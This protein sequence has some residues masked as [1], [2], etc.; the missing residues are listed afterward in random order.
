MSWQLDLLEPDGVTPKATRTNQNPTGVLGGFGWKSSRYGNCITCDF[1]GHMPSLGLR[2]RDLVRLTINGTS[3][4]YGPAVELPQPRDPK[5]GVVNLVGA[6]DL[7]ERRVIGPQVY[8]NMDVALI[9]RDLISRHRHPAL[10]YDPAAI[11]LTGK[12]LS[13]FTMPWRTLRQALESLGKT[14]GGDQGVPFGV[15]PSGVVFFGAPANPP[16]VLPYSAVSKSLKYLRVSGDDVVTQSYLIALSQA[17]GTA[18]SSTR[19]YPVGY[20]VESSGVALTVSEINTSYGVPYKPATYTVLAE[21]ADWASVGA[22]ATHLIPDG[23]DVITTPGVNLPVPQYVGGLLNSAN[24]LDGNVTTYAENDPAEAN[25][26]IQFRQEMGVN[27]DPIIGFRL[28]YSLTLGN[29]LYQNEVT[30]QYSYPNPA[31]QTPSPRGGGAMMLLYGTATFDFRLASTQGELRELIA[32]RPMPDEFLTDTLNGPFTA[33]TPT[34]LI[35]S[36]NAGV[37]S[38]GTEHLP[39]GAFKIYS[40]E[41]IRLDRAKVDTLARKYLVPPAQ[42]PTEFILPY[43]LGPTPSVTLTGL[44]GG[45]LTGDVA[46]IEGKHDSK[47]LTQSIVKLEQPGASEASRII[48]LVARGRAG[49]AQTEL[50]GYLER[51]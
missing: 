42:E 1:E 35:V 41:P 21:D 25:S 27:E 12:V 31:G 43:L 32:V 33:T 39:A 7:L 47:G 49:D 3:V 45:N 22:Q 14:I 23:A 13:E 5:R 18:P 6:A 48:R 29:G 20:K 51:S 50:R 38:I 34:P 44:P 24:A 10:T 2:N 9:A 8:N 37:N 40:F 30:L 36:L 11:P 4:F 46:E 28:V 26:Y 19:N 15:W 17:A 16:L